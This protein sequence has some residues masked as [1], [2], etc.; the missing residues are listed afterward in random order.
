MNISAW[1]GEFIQD[2]RF[3]MR[4]L[5][6]N[7][8][9]TAVAVITLALGIGANTAVFSVLDGVV[10]APLPYRQPERLVMIWGYSDTLKHIIAM[11]YLDFRDW[12]RNAKCFQGLAAHT[13]RS[14]NLTNPGDAEHL[15]GEEV[16]AGFF[17]T[18]GVDLEAG[19]EFHSEEDRRGG[20]RSVI[21]SDRLWRERLG[22]NPNALGKVITL[23]A[24]DYTIVGVAPVQFKFTGTADVYT[25]LGQGDPATIDDR[26]IHS[27]GAVARLRDGVS[28]AEAQEQMSAVQQQLDDLYPQVERGLGIKVMALKDYVVGPVGGTIFLL[29]GAVGLILLIACANVANLLLARGVS[30]G[31]EFAVRLALGASRSRI[32][33]QTIAENMLLALIGCGFGLLL[34]KW[35]VRPM[36]ALAPGNLPRSENV[37][38]NGGAF[39]FAF[40]VSIAAGILVGLV[41]ALRNWR[42]DLQKS[43]RTG[44]RGATP[45]HHRVQSSLAILQMALTLVVLVGAG[46]L[47]R[48]IR[49]LWEVNPGFEARHVMAFQVGLPAAMTA[50]PANS[51]IAYQKLIARVRAIPGVDAADITAL[52]PMTPADNSGP[53]WVGTARPASLAEAPRAL[54]YWVGA[55]YAHTMQIPLLAG[56]FLQADDTVKT[57]RVV[58]IDNNL[59]RGYFSGIDPVGKMLVVP[60]WGEARVVGVVGH[61]KHWGPNEPQNFV[62][63]QIYASFYQL[64]DNLVGVFSPYMAVTLRTSLSESAVMPEIKRA[65]SASGSDEPIY[66]VRTMEKILSASLAPERFP[67]TL[68]G[69]FAAVALALSSIGIY[70]VI[71]YSV[72]QRAHEIGIRIA[73]GAERKNIF[74]MV[75]GEGIRLAIAGIVIGAAASLVLTRAISG[76]SRL[77]YGVQPGD[78]LTFAAVATGLTLVAMVACYVPARRA[79]KVDPIVAL[80]CD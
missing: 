72:G 74:R 16:S 27:F 65:V 32:V 79:T 7:P 19:R 28:L 5:M 77:L 9:F 33:R 24:V 49:N 17:S 21:L 20:A 73:L 25:P 53:F 58:V 46:L 78:P 64:P 38:L 13:G 1:F 67:M 52:V 56:R 3:G 43:L 80:R 8:G 45:A 39:L 61:V 11:S 60:H 15:N 50:T 75:I 63:N 69:A 62:Q 10:L 47:L 76:Y 41:P 22:G 40:G 48:T 51:R 66:A 12:Q 18:L 54:Y 29:F 34:A 35:S 55:D 37:A 4:Q 26:S 57:E 59:A 14:F 31:P 71:S 6:R 2:V 36:L 44:R 30:R 23:D 70:G 42:T 68:L